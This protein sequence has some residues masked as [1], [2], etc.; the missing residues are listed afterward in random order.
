MLD[1]TKYEY[2]SGSNWVKNAASPM[3]PSE[4]NYFGAAADIIPTS[5]NAGPEFSVAFDAYANRYIMMLVHNRWA[6][7]TAVELWQAANITGPW[8]K[9]TNGAS[10]LPNANT[11]GGQW[12]P[13]DFFYGPYTSEHIMRNGGQNIYFQLSEWNG[14]FAA[15]PYNVGL[16]TFNIDRTLTTSCT[17]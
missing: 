14:L 4:G 8:T 2:W 3:A 6:A 13:Y 7:G 9:V 11:A 16:W 15:R 17:P 1:R 5:A 12:L 10:N